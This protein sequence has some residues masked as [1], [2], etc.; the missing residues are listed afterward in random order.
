MA[1]NKT[2][3]R[4]ADR[5]RLNKSEPYE[6]AYAKSDRASPERKAMLAKSQSETAGRTGNGSSRG[7]SAKRAAKSGAKKAS[8]SGARKSASSS[9]RGTSSSRAR[10]SSSSGARKS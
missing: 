2:R 6:V 4:S 3:G 1:D 9:S 5:K 10:K 8:G 7:A